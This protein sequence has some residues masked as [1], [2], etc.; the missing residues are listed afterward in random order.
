MK[1]YESATLVEL[2]NASDL[3]LGDE[4]LPPDSTDGP[5]QKEATF[6]DIDE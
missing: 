5:W 4:G 2:G 6:L 1:T 3:V